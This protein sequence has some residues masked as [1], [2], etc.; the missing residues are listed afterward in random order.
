VT[1]QLKCLEAHP[2]RQ[3][4]YPFERKLVAAPPITRR[5]RLPVRNASACVFSVS[6]HRPLSKGRWIKVTLTGRASQVLR[7][8]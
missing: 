5:V 7:R 3:H 1:V 8:I 4:W 2:Q 6:A